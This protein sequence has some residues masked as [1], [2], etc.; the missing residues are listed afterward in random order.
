MGII[1]NITEI[2]R[3]EIALKQAA[4]IFENIQTGIYIYELE[5]PDDDRS[6]RLIAANP[7]SEILTGAPLKDIIGKTIDEN[8]PGLRKKGIP[9]MYFEVIRTKSQFAID[10]L[11]YSD[12]RVLE[13]A[14]SIKAF[15]LPNQRIG[16]AFE[17]I[18]ERIEADKILRMSE[19]RYRT[20]FEQ[21]ADGIMVGD[22]S[23]KIINA[24]NNIL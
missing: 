15:S 3:N 7:A 2:K 5:D 21:A 11:Y 12:H 8:F 14:F 10:D 19:E 22:N 23:G 13:G 9:Q 4:D 6:L 24:N 1:K 18:T 17:S 20:L 16:I